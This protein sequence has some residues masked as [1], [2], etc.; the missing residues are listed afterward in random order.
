[1]QGKRERLEI[2]G[3]DYPTP[4]GTCVRDYI[5]VEDLAEAHLLALESLEPGKELKLNLGI[6]RGYSVREVIRTVEEV[7]GKP[8]PVKE[9][10]RREGDPPSLVAASDRARQILGWQP[11]YAELRPIVETAWRWHHTHPNGY[12]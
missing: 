5:H 6:G 12:E 8:V 3:T 7:T 10:P 4:D 11:R 2:F 1:V 9:G